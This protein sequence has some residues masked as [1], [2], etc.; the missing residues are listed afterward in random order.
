MSQP[1]ADQAGGLPTQ[2]STAAVAE[3]MPATIVKTS[4][5]STVLGAMFPM[6]TSAIGLSYQRRL[7][8]I[9]GAASLLTVYPAVKS[10]GPVIDRFT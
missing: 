10:V 2:S 6:A 4:L 1:S 9:G 7:L 5:R 8:G 3:K